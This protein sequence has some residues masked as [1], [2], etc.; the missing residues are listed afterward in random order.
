MMSVRL[1]K[2]CRVA[3]LCAVA[4]SAVSRVHARLMP[5]PSQSGDPIVRLEVTQAR[6]FKTVLNALA[7]Q[8]RVAFV[9]EGTPFKATL[10]D[11]QMRVLCDSDAPLSQTVSRLAQAYDYSVESRS[12]V[13][14]LKKCYTDP[15]EIPNVTLDEA[16][17]A[18][19]EAKRILN[20]I[21]PYSPQR[22]VENDPAFQQF[23]LSLTPEQWQATKNETL[24]VSSLKPF[25]QQQIRRLALF[26]FVQL[27]AQRKTELVSSKLDKVVGQDIVLCWRT[28]PLGERLFGYGQA[29]RVSKTPWFEPLS[30]PATFI[31]GELPLEFGHAPGQPFADPTTPLPGADAVAISANLDT[32]ESTVATLNKTLAARAPDPPVITVDSALAAKPVTVAGLTNASPYEVLSACADVYGLRVMEQDNGRTR[33]LT[34]RALFLPGDVTRLSEALRR[35]FPDP[36]LRALHRDERDRARDEALRAAQPNS[37]A[38]QVRAV[39][40][41]QQAEQEARFRRWQNAPL[42]LRTAAVRRLRAT[43]EPKVKQALNGELPLSALDEAEKSALAAALMYGCLSG[44]NGVLSR[45]LPEYILHFDRLILTGEKYVEDGEDKFTM[46]LKLPGLEG[47]SPRTMVGFSNARVPQRQRSNP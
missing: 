40:A 7:K 3:L 27:F 11:E 36:F 29:S 34:R 26:Y 6:D 35:V 15:N 1:L 16:R 19:G 45:H 13:Y 43:V 8:G 31:T 14:R 44:L 20:A 23:V 38:E 21:S 41:E 9:A 42:A 32:L 47:N 2:C 10:T 46:M 5:G 24:R 30:T 22:P 4:F 17:L 12:G 37:S 18:A 25:Q 28:H 33:R 39:V